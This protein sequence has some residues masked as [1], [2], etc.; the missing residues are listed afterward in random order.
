MQVT[1]EQGTF[2]AGDNELQ[3]NLELFLVGMF[4]MVYSMCVAT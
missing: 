4:V 2:S 1:T 3:I